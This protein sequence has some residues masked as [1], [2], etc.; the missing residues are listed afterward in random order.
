MSEGLNEN[1]TEDPTPQRRDR[2][3]EEGQVVYSP[4]LNSAVAIFLVA[5]AAAWTVP[6]LAGQLQQL[7]R[8]RILNLSGESWSI[9]ATQMAVGWLVSNLWTLTGIAAIAFLAMNLLLSQIQTGFLF[10][11]KPLSPNWEKLNMVQGFQ[12]LWSL[13]SFVRGMLA[14]VKIGTLS[15]LTAIVFWNWDQKLMRDTHGP[16]DHS[17]RLGWGMLVQ[18]MSSLA[19]AALTWGL[20][21]YGFRWFRNEQKLRMS[22]DEIKDEQ[23][24]ENGDP[25]I[26]A[27]IRRMQKEAAQRKT[28]R[29]VPQ[30]TVVITNPTHYAVA[31]KYQSGTMK[32]P[33]VVAKGSGAF[34]RR[35]AAVARQHGVPVLER[36]PLTRALYALADVGKEIPLEYFRAV[37]EILAYVYR[38]K[39]AG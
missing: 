26:R 2:A 7:I 5:I 1:K 23:K 4:D 10:T 14:L 3:R 18:L 13:D 17:V 24:A 32:A 37:A 25:Q 21:D 33:R 15:V 39:N 29:D 16:L 6:T 19:V 28:L 20:A 9:P 12:R 35:I 36:K 34:A 38:L 27:Q 8:N 30:A 11:S 31:L 22:R